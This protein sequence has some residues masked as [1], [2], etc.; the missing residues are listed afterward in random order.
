MAHTRKNDSGRV[1][2]KTEPYKRERFNNKSWINHS[3]AVNANKPKPEVI[4]QQE[5]TLE[6]EETLFE[7]LYSDDNTDG[8]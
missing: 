8:N 3:V 5:L 2:P 6:T 4:Q 1:R 7:V